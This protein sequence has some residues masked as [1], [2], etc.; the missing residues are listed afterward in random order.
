MENDCCPTDFSSRNA[1]SWHRIWIASSSMF[2][3]IHGFAFRNPSLSLATLFLQF[4]SILLHPSLSYSER[5]A[6]QCP[7]QDSR[8]GSIDAK[9]SDRRRNS[10]SIA[11]HFYRDKGNPKASTGHAQKSNRSPTHN[12]VPEAGTPVNRLHGALQSMVTIDSTKVGSWYWEASSEQLRKEKMSMEGSIAIQQQSTSSGNQLF[13][14]N[15]WWTTLTKRSR[16]NDMLERNSLKDINGGKDN[17]AHCTRLNRV[18][19]ASLLIGP[20][21][22]VNVIEHDSDSVVGI[23]WVGWSWSR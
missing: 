21:S 5:L 17:G 1:E 13:Q 2:M 12:V 4:Y 9:G 10:V 14:N 6:S 22:S 19:Q 7:R 11:N 15:I 16:R 8:N 18:C 20:A 23:N 3:F